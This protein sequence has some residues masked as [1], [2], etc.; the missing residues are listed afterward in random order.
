M[1]NLWSRHGIYL[2]DEGRTEESDR[3]DIREEAGRVTRKVQVSNTLY[4]A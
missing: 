3:R 2:R 1:V 4:T